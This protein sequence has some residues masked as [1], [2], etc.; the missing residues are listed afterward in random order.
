VEV[1][2]I[3]LI[4]AACVPAF[5]P[6]SAQVP[7]ADFSYS[8]VT[9]GSWG[10]RA[11]AG[12][13]E[14]TFVDT[15]GTARLAVACGRVTRLVTLSRIS[16]APA[17]SLS[18]WTSSAARNLGA[19]FDQRSGRVIAQVSA[20]DPLLDAIAFS[21]GRFALTMPGFPALVLPADPELAHVFE[22]CRA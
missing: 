22:D 8:P 7:A 9:P 21:R 1:K 6:V 18:L 3:A 13:S 19:T 15:T 14:A 2:R 20:N 12:G 5:G 17:S 11:V 4:A 10:Y 16:A